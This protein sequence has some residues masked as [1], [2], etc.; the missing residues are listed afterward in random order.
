MILIEAAIAILMVTLLAV[1]T[2][3]EILVG[4]NCCAY[5]NGEQKCA[6]YSTQAAMDSFFPPGTRFN[7]T[8]GTQ[9]QGSNNQGQG[10]YNEADIW[11]F[12]SVCSI[13]NPAS[14]VN[15]PGAFPGMTKD[16][17][18]YLNCCWDE[19]Y[20][21]YPWCF[22]NR[23]YIKTKKTCP[24]NVPVS[25]TECPGA[26]VGMIKETCDG[27]YGGNCCWDPSV[28]TSPFCFTNTPR[29][30]C[31]TYPPTSRRECP[32]AYGGMSKTTCD[33]LDGGRCCWDETTK[34]APYCYVP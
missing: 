21:T 24:V 2:E 9:G 20:K 34:N 30:W 23:V 18:K 1:K 19:T 22:S 16:Y 14:R 4:S 6:I 3:A 31:P 10:S 11:E 29:P 13:E 26:Y 27:L 12:R 25:R 33:G 8:Y 7:C 5:V 32:G 28:A 15:C 17:C